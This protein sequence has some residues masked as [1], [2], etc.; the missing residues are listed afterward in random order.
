MLF[1]I[2]SISSFKF[3]PKA[4]KCA[5]YRSKRGEGLINNPHQL[6]TKFVKSQAKVGCSMLATF[7]YTFIN[8][9]HDNIK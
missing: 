6:E 7:F 9:N 3:L 1:S 5:E 2:H 4:G 8:L